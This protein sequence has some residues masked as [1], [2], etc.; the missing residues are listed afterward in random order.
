MRFEILLRLSGCENF[1]G[2]S[3]NGPPVELKWCETACSCAD[4]EVDPLR[5]LLGT[6]IKP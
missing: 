4:S 2:T 6:S 5:R 3:R 1:F